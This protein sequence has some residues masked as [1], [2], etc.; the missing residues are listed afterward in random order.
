MP[1][2]AGLIPMDSVPVAI[3]VGP[4]GALY[5]GELTGFPFPVGGANV[6]RVVP[7]Q[8][9]TVYA[10]GF[11]NIID[12]DFGRDGSLYVAEI[13]HFGLLSGNRAGGI[14]RVPPGGGTPQL[15]TTS[16]EAPGGLAVA[17]DQSL[18]V[19]T[20]ADCANTGGVVKIVP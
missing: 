13:S 16:V 11:T 8:Q 19:D 9:P 12:L 1:F 7:G 14:W 2:G 15:L 5:V 20:C 17:R 3:T 6:Y 18:Y 4:D 10:T